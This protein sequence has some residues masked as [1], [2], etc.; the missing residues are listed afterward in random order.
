MCPPDY[1]YNGK[2]GYVPATYL[3]KSEAFSVKKQKVVRASI[4]G[5]EIVKT[6]HD[7]S[8]LLK[9]RDCQNSP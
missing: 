9:V 1:R 7:I 4:G 8:D 2:E 5:P 3:M 6:L